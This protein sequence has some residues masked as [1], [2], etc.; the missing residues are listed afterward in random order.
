MSVSV[1]ESVSMVWAKVNINVYVLNIELNGFYTEDFY[2]DSKLYCE[3]KNKNKK[4]EEDDDLDR[5]IEG[6]I[7]VAISYGR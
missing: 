2:Y 4:S 5:K 1:S 7:N 6:K 3:N